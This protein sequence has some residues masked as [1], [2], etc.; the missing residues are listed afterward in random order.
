VRDL[1]RS[2]LLIAYKSLTFLAINDHWISASEYVAADFSLGCA[3]EGFDGGQHVCGT[4]LASDGGGK[5]LC[6][7][8]DPAVGDCD[9]N[10]VGQPVG[11]EFALRNRC[12]AGVEFL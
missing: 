11:S 7:V 12:R 3:S 2:P 6:C 8:P 10:R 5:L 4:V 9:V 1:L